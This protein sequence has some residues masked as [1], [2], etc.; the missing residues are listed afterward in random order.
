M[1]H[2]ASN[3]LPSPRSK[4]YDQSEKKTVAR[5]FTLVRGRIAGP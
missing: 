4:N 5:I 3:E 2:S 1:N